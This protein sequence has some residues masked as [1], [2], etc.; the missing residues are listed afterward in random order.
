MGAQYLT[1]HPEKLQDFKD[2]ADYVILKV[3]KNIHEDTMTQA[4]KARYKE[5]KDKFGN[6]GWH[7]LSVEGLAKATKFESAYDTFYREACAI[8]HGSALPLLT[9]RYGVGCRDIEPTEETAEGRDYGAMALI[10]GTHLIFSILEWTNLKFGFGYDADLKQF[11]ES[12][13]R[14]GWFVSVLD[15][16]RVD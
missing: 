9:P 6:R 7:R 10:Y 13:E 4:E 12:C 5:L 1:D 2:E 14:R 3:L 8:T 11:W 15:N 16:E